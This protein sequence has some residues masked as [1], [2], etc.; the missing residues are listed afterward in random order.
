MQLKDGQ[1]PSGTA[2]KHSRSE[3]GATQATL[4]H[5]RDRTK[6]LARGNDTALEKEKADPDVQ[7]RVCRLEACMSTFGAL[8][9]DSQQDA[10]GGLMWQQAVERQ[11]RAVVKNAE[12]VTICR[13]MMAWDELSELMAKHKLTVGNLSQTSVEGFIHSSSGLSRAP[14]SLRW[15]RKHLEGLRTGGCCTDEEAAEGVTGGFTLPESG[16][17]AELKWR[18]RKCG[19]GPHLRVTCPSPGCPNSWCGRCEDRARFC[20]VCRRRPRPPPEPPP[21]PPPRRPRPPPGPPP[22]RPGR[23]CG[24]GRLAGAGGETDYVCGQS[25]CVQMPPGITELKWRC[26]TCGAGPHMR[27]WC[28]RVDCS[29]SWCANCG[30]TPRYC[31]ECWRDPPP[32]PPGPPPRRDTVAPPEPD[33]DGKPKPRRRERCPLCNRWRD[34]VC[35]EC[36]AGYCT[37]CPGKYGGCFGLCHECARRRMDRMGVSGDASG[38]HP[39]ASVRSAPDSWQSETYREAA[40]TALLQRMP[41]ECMMT[42]GETARP[43]EFGEEEVHDGPLV[44][45]PETIPRFRCIVCKQSNLPNDAMHLPCGFSVC[46]LPHNCYFRHISRCQTCMNAS[47]DSGDDAPSAPRASSTKGKQLVHRDGFDWAVPTAFV[48]QEVSTQDFNWAE[49]QVMQMWENRSPEKQ[50]M[51]SMAFD[52]ELR[53]PQSNECMIQEARM[54]LAHLVQQEKLVKM[55]TCSWQR[56]SATGGESAKF[57]SV[58]LCALG[59]WQEPS[60]LQ[61]AVVAAVPPR[62]AGHKY[63]EN[64][65]VESEFHNSMSRTCHDSWEVVPHNLWQEQ[66]GLSLGPVATVSEQD[67]ATTLESTRLGARFDDRVRWVANQGRN[68]LPNIAGRLLAPKGLEGNLLRAAFRPGPCKE[69]CPYERRCDALL[70][71]GRACSDSRHAAANCQTKK[72]RMPAEFHTALFGSDGQQDKLGE[73][74]QQRD[75]VKE[76]L[77]SA[78]QR[79]QNRCVEEPAEGEVRAN[80][81]KSAWR[82]GPGSAAIASQRRAASAKCRQP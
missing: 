55:A 66:R 71:S 57:N 68:V 6:V 44:L 79:V 20:K 51:C 27:V 38:G 59:D 42:P 63:S 7:D 32:P 8:K 60:Q 73:Q 34:G 19:A 26:H 43:R 47:D 82:P 50:Q 2:A 75:L 36:S 5:Y 33:S 65:S 64:L 48:T 37:K 58:E 22:R 16:A 31:S 17:E 56:I 29:N 15:M 11:A 9:E 53:W 76:H 40:L 77:R 1:S 4:L 61:K 52:A 54:A 10:D 81:G 18:C 39:S 46:R 24:S 45:P 30:G 14:T 67:Q 49:K 80:A 35:S 74:D 13:A 25:C 28:M 72:A 70:K 78:G 3:P 23:L 69:F 12:P 62:Y 21:D 41:T